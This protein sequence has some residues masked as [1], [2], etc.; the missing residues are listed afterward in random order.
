MAQGPRA[1]APPGLTNPLRPWEVLKIVNPINFPTLVR[2]RTAKH[3]K[4][5]LKGKLD[6]QAIA[7][8]NEEED[9]LTGAERFMGFRWAQGGPMG[10]PW[11]MGPCAMVARMAHCP[12]AHGFPMLAASPPSLGN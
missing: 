2:L 9:R 8:G 4:N 12:L 6:V 7:D 3:Y 11:A 10:C 5:M 1:K